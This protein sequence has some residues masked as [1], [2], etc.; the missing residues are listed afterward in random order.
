[1]L[2]KYIVL[3]QEKIARNELE[4]EALP[5][6]QNLHYSMYAHRSCPSASVRCRTV[7]CFLL[8]SAQWIYDGSRSLGHGW[9]VASCLCLTYHTWPECI[10]WQLITLPATP[11]DLYVDGRSL[12]SAT[13]FT[14]PILSK[15]KPT[16]N[17]FA[18][19]ILTAIVAVHEYRLSTHRLRF[20]VCKQRFFHW[21]T[22]SEY[23]L[24]C[25]QL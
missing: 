9:K 19:K 25:G 3:S 12:F 6:P 24:A 7:S 22:L 23:S 13:P 8:Q 16:D 4:K 2:E 10:T 14:P 17:E 1:M 5:V 15:Y 11:R 21:V 18:G 20:P